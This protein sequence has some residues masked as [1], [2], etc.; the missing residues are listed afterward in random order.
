MWKKVAVVALVAGAL[1]AGGCSRKPPPPTVNESMTQIIAPQTQTIWDI[2]SDAFNARGD[3]LLAS[4]ISDADWIRLEKAGQQLNDRALVLAQSRRMVVAAPGETVMGSEASGA[5]SPIG[6][7]WDAA[8]AAIV[9]S[10]ID[11]NPALFARHA[12]T[13]AE[14]GAAIVKASRTRDIKTLYEVSSEMDEVCDGCHKP[15]WGTDEPPPFPH[16]D[17]GRTSAATVHKGDERQD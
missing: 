3:G 17:A 15:F 16:A 9:Q 1:L 12:R 7:E 5:P 4:K 14:A 2:T 8:S 10:R 6:H 11:A 13:L